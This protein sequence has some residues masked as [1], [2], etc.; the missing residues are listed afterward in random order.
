LLFYLTEEKN[1]F[2]KSIIRVDINAFVDLKCWEENNEED[3]V[4]TAWYYSVFDNTEPITKYLGSTSNFILGYIKEVDEG[5][6]YC[7]VALSI[8]PNK[9]NSSEP[10]K[11]YI[12]KT[13]IVV[14]GKKMCTVWQL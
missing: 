10:K 7:Y 9:T 11:H 2:Q 4:E 1:L 5:Y 14:Y 8:A 13:Q 12:G 3:T 6:Y